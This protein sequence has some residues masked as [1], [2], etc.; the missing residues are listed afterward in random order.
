MKTDLRSILEAAAISA[1][2]LLFPACDGGDDEAPAGVTETEAAPGTSAGCPGTSAGCPGTSAGCPGT[3]AGCPSN[4]SSTGAGAERPAEV[5]AVLAAIEDE[6]YT[7]WEAEPMVHPPGGGSPHPNNL[8][9]FFN[10]ALATSMGMSN[11]E[12]PVGAAA[13]KE[14]WDGDELVGWFIEVKIAEGA[15]PQTWYWWSDLAGVD[16]VGAAGVGC[17]DCHAAGV[18]FV[19]T[20]YPFE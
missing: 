11:T 2:T 15:G 20:E 14:S 18:D 1:S 16:T 3:S 6:S 10:P 8:R 4:D 12:H 17:S 9:T 7:S 19:T 13:I 5:E